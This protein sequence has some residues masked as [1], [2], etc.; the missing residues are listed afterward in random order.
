MRLLKQDVLRGLPE[1]ARGKTIAI[2]TADPVPQ[3]ATGGFPAI[4]DHNS[5]DVLRSTAHHRPQPA[6]VDRFEHEAPRFVIRQNVIWIGRQYSVLAFG[7]AFHM[8]NESISTCFGG[9]FRRPATSLA[10][11]CARDTP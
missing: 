9:A 5:A 4:T 1:I 7:Q 2:L 11:S 8:I 10:S 3:A 6:F